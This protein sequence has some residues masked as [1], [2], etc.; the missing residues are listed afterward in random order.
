[1]VKKFLQSH[2]IVEQP[3]VRRFAYTDRVSRDSVASRSGKNTGVV[4]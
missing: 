2:I 1:M 3:S 4:D